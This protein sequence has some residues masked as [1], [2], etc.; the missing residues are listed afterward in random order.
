MN[1]N[2]LEDFIKMQKDVE[3][4]KIDI[5]EIKVCLKEFTE[6]AEKRYAGKWVEK[7]MFFI[8]GVI[9]TGIV[10]AMLDVIIKK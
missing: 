9:G 4:I 5:G 1:E 10:V 7:I 8:G 3:N 2:Q 6:M